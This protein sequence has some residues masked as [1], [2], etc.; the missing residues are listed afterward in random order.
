M[1][2]SLTFCV[3]LAM[4]GVGA[5]A[6][7]Q[8]AAAQELFEQ[9]R[10][11]LAAG[12]LETAC[13]R[14]RAS[15]KLE[16]AAGTKA[17]LAT[18]EEKRGR[19]ATAWEGFK[20][21]LRGLP[22]DDPRRAK[23]Q[24]RIEALA[25]RLPRLELALAPGTPA[26]TVATEGGATMGT[27][28]WGIALPFDPG[29]H[30]VLVS[31]P[32]HAPWTL[33]VVLEE[34]KTKRVTIGAEPPASAAPVD[35][36]AA[37]GR[38]LPASGGPSVGPW[39]IGGVGVASLVAGG[40]LGGLVLHA[41]NVND[42]GCNAFQQTC[43]QPAKDAAKLGGALGPATTVALIVGA[44]GVAGGALWLGLRDP[45]PAKPRVGVGVG[46]LRLEGSW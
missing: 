42:A 20:E 14:F 45:A 30:K 31:A 11:A 13:S 23:I 21:A 19:I 34:G 44:A 7:A 41:K 28:T 15:D 37:P 29:V 9:G 36:V 17:N 32:G 38:P 6:R 26:E 33:D 43:T 10:V 46:S 39:V 22:H 2:T 3:S 18:C 27:G 24:E 1:R 35:P 4:L 5:T 40:V 25:P 8:G 16:P 12:E